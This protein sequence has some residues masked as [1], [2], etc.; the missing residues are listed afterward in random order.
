MARDFARLRRK[1]QGLSA[2]RQELADRRAFDELV[3]QDRQA[4][5]DELRAQ[6]DAAVAAFRGSVQVLDTH[7]ALRCR[8]CGHRGTARVRRGARPKFRC[9]NCGSSL[10]AVRV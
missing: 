5:K 10:V 3:P 4:E 6:A 7:V 8:T 2:I 1:A 9:R